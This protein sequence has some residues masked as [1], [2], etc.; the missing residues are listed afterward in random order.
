MDGGNDWEKVTVDS[1]KQNLRMGGGGKK[2]DDNL[3]AGCVV[4][5][6]VIGVAFLAYC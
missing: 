2:R 3:P 1:Y 5:L 6:I 4:V